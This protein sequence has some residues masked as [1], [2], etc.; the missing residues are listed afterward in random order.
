MTYTW[1]A[2]SAVVIAIVLDLFIARTGLLRSKRFWTSYSIIVFFQLLTNWWLT[3]REIV[4]YSPDAILGPRIAS[5]PVED[6]LFGFSLVLLVLVLWE[7][8]D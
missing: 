2:I 5:A 3:S 8:E 6:L 4:K 7:K 1:I